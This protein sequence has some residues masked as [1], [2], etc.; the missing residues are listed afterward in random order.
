MSGS[1]NTPVQIL[2]LE[3]DPETSALITT[4]LPKEYQH[5]FITTVEEAEALLDAKL[6]D[7]FICAD[8]LPVESG[9]MFLARTRNK[10]P[11]LRRLLMMPDPDGELYFH[12]LREVPRLSYLS[13]PFERRAFHRAVR[14]ALWEDRS[15]EGR[16]LDAPRFVGIDSRYTPPEENSGP[17]E[18]PFITST[19][20]VIVE[21][22]SLAASRLITMLPWGFRHRIA[23]TV[24]EAE[25][26]L[27]AQP[28]DL[29][30][31]SDD[32]PVESGLMFLAR[33][34]NRW[35]TTKR[36]LL[37]TEPDAEF[38]FHASRELPCLLYLAKPVKKSDLLHVLRHGLHDIFTDND[39]DEP[40][41]DETAPAVSSSLVRVLF[42]TLVLLIAACFVFGVM[43]I[44]YQLKC[45]FGPDIFPGTNQLPN[46]LQH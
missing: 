19:D 33:T 40:A 11:T 1:L 29:L 14:H 6:P 36:I 13:K 22:D 24:E 5:R 32:L 20:V 12:A 31:C 15:I 3:T 27:D 10:W 21:I 28:S 34:R 43:A 44:I 39:E 38:F 17:I 25:A 16:E 42:V 26:L 37:V 30:L 18:T 45:W 2:V 7:L 23:A 4:L 35:P 8:D 9:L 41:A 46:F